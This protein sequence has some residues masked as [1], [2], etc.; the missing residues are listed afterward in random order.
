MLV[1]A[2]IKRLPSSIATKG[3]HE[4]A[5]STE[6]SAVPNS[7]GTAAAVRLTG[8]ESLNHSANADRRGSAT[9]SPTRVPREPPTAIPEIVSKH[10]RPS[11]TAPSPQLRQKLRRPA[12]S[13]A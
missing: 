4:N 9:R 1:A 6:A 12:E 8:R 11:L 7:T 10:D 13:E 5:P 2:W 3:P